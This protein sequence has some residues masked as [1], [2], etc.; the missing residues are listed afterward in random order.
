MVDRGQL[1]VHFAYLAGLERGALGQRLLSPFAHAPLFLPPSAASWQEL[2]E[3]WVPARPGP[4][5][6]FGAAYESASGARAGGG[7]MAQGASAWACE[8]WPWGW[9]EGILGALSWWA[10]GMCVGRGGTN[11]HLFLAPTLSCLPLHL[12]VS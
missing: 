2:G 5:W 1:L 3:P 8:G 7:A 10:A 12:R 9:P 11:R 4:R 6:W